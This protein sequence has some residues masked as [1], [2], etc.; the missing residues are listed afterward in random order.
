MSRTTLV[1][2]R[3]LVII[4]VFGA[5]SMLTLAIPI[6]VSSMKRIPIVRF[7][8]SRILLRGEKKIADVTFGK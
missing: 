4:I 7:V 2:F 5:P 6:L 1:V 3:L 8:A